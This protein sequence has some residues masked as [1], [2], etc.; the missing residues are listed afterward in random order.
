MSASSQPSR[1]PRS[2]VALGIVVLLV[3][4]VGSA[5]AAPPPES[6]CGIC[7]DSLPGATGDGTLEIRVD[8]AGDS[9]WV[10]RVPVNAST[11]GAYQE[12]GIDLVVDVNERWHPDD[13]ATDD[14]T[15][16]QTRVSDGEVVVEYTVE[17]V[18]R[19]GTGGAWIVEYFYRG[20]TAN[21]YELRANAVTIT[22]PDGTVVTNQPPNANVE[23]RSVTWTQE[24]AGGIGGVS[25]RTY[26]TYADDG[27]GG[28]VA[29]MAT[30]ARTFGPAKVADG[31]V[32]ATVPVAVLGVGTAVL[33][34]V[35]GRWN[36]RPTAVRR[37]ARRSGASRAGERTVSFLQRRAVGGRGLLLGA[38]SAGAGVAA[39][40]WLTVG[41]PARINVAAFVLGV[42]LLV[43]FGYAVGTGRRPWA[44]G[45]FVALVPTLPLLAYAPYARPIPVGLVYVGWS[46]L[47]I[48]IGAPLSVG[49]WRYGRTVVNDESDTES[50]V[51][52]RMG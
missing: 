10:A 34:V 12:N 40:G 27:V 4:S 42:G 9:R 24:S 31:S 48:L 28:Q 15:N 33:G 38:L 16:I 25:S 35:I 49:G 17:D 50:Q 3:A 7:G 46:L 43:P 8:E 39:A 47:V 13:V 21:R 19:E 51:S 36:R 23:K 41:W 5:V 1:W 14:K 32:A 45:V 52:T 22:V 29:S 30:A 6:L 18:A 20:G 11:A 44:L 37:L 26:L 2:L